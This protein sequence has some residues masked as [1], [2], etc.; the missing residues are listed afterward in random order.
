MAAVATSSPSEDVRL[1]GLATRADVRLLCA[2]LEPVLPLVSVAPAAV[3]HTRR[4]WNR[5]VLDDLTVVAALRTAVL[6]DLAVVA[7]LR[8]AVLDDLA[9]MAAVRSVVCRGPHPIVSPS[10]VVGIAAVPD[11]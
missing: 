9:A 4:P 3:L 10:L 11:I 1:R 7:T 6:D 2:P 5:A 8:T